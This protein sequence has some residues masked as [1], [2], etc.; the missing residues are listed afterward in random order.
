[1]NDKSLISELSESKMFPSAQTLSKENFNSLSE[2]AH[3]TLVTLRI[4]L[5]E[6]STHAWAKTYVQKTLRGG[7]FK[8]WRSDANDLYTLLYALSTGHYFE[9]GYHTVT[10]SP[11]ERWLRD[12]SHDDK[13]DE[14]RTH[15][16][17]LRLDGILRIHDTSMK[18]V[19]RL[20][21]DWADLTIHEKR[22]AVTRLLQMLRARAPRSEVLMK[23]QV[24]SRNKEFELEDV[25]NQETGECSGDEGSLNIGTKKE[26][27]KYSLL[28]ILAIGAGY[29]ASRALG[30]LREEATAG[31]TG[32]ASVAS[33]TTALGAETLGPGFNSNGNKGIYQNTK[34]TVLRRGDPPKKT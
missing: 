28:P 4:L 2:A 9:G 33:V 13:G 31:A 27:S 7:H 3:L 32:A 5:H 19:R 26:K 11:I 17:F 30:K 12:V 29:A 10:V 21:M 15:T 22:L 1:M 24:L 8:S 6:K 20:V 23:L 18:A 14:G 25:C 16:F 34:P